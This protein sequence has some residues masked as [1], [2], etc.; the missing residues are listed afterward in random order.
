MSS[1]GSVVLPCAV[2]LCLSSP[3]IFW[4]CCVVFWDLT[5]TLLQP[6]VDVSLTQEATYSWREFSVISVSKPIKWMRYK[7]ELSAL[8][9]SHTLPVSLSGVGFSFLFSWVLMGVITALFLA[10]GNLEKLVCE[11]FQTR[12]LFKVRETT[13]HLAVRFIMFIIKVWD[14]SENLMFFI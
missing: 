10:G 1:G 14:H 12:Q 13:Q 7:T 8:T 3:S 6:H 4:D 2:W 9:H 11:P 5:G